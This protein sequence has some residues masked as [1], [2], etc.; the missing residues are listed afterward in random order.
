MRYFLVCVTF[1]LC[2]KCEPGFRGDQSQKSKQ[3]LCWKVHDRA[4]SFVLRLYTMHELRNQNVSISSSVRSE[5]P[6]FGACSRPKKRT[7]TTKKFVGFQNHS[8][9]HVAKFCKNPFPVLGSD[10]NMDLTFSRGTML[11]RG[12][13]GPGAW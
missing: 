6:V 7:N 11:L 5:K 9:N 12:E 8:F 4:Q 13:H 2:R 3:N 1:P 10:R